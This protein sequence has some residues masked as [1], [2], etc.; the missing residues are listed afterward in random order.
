MS[1]GISLTSPRWLAIRNL[2]VLIPAALLWMVASCGESSAAQTI[3]GKSVLPPKGKKTNSENTPPHNH[4]DEAARNTTVMPSPSQPR[5]SG[6]TNEEES[7]PSSITHNMQSP[8]PIPETQSHEVNDHDQEIEEEKAPIKI[9]IQLTNLQPR[10][11][12]LV[13]IAVYTSSETFLTSQFTL[14]HCKS[15]DQ[16]T[17]VMLLPTPGKYAF[18]ALHDADNNERLSKN[19]FGIPK[20]GFGFSNNP[21]ILFGPPKFESVS[22]YISNASDIWIHMRYFLE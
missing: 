7:G 14:S 8:S 6:S 22:T 18:T 21:R 4:P 19:F 17:I 16:N 3:G 13:C 10:R 2:A 11:G 1:C 5:N 20:E 9:R 12:G 15:P